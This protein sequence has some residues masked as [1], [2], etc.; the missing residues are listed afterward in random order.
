MERFQV[1]LRD[2]QL[3][4]MERIRDERGIT[5]AEMIRRA[6]DAYLGLEFGKK[7]RRIRVSKEFKRLLTEGLDRVMED[8]WG[9]LPGA[10]ETR[11]A[12]VDGSGL[13]S[14][15]KWEWVLDSSGPC[16]VVEPGQHDE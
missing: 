12:V 10:K 8:K 9:N 7:G 14:D 1:H 3:S 11:D 4:V 2:D 13:G 5:I 15:V 6:V 16:E